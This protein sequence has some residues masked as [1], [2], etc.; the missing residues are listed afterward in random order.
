MLVRDAGTVRFRVLIPSPPPLLPALSRVSIPPA[1][2]TPLPLLAL[3]LLPFLQAAD[4]RAR[5]GTKR[6][7]D[8]FVD[9]CVLAIN[10]VAQAPTHADPTDALAKDGPVGSSGAGGNDS[11]EAQGRSPCMGPIAAP[12]SA[13][14]AGDGETPVAVAGTTPVPGGRPSALHVPA[15]SGKAPGASH[16]PD[17]SSPESPATTAAAAPSYLSAS[18]KLEFFEGARLAM[19][20]TALCLS[21]GGALAM[22]HMG[23]VRALIQADTMPRIVSGTS[24]GAIV[25]GMLAIRTDK[26][27]V[28]DVI[29]SDI[30]DRYGVT[31][32]DPIPTQVAT[33]AA[34]LLTSDRPYTM[35]SERFAATCKRYFG[36][37]TF[38][39]AFRRTGRVVSIVIT[40]RYGE[41]GATHPFLA[42]YLTCPTV[43]IWSAVAAS[44]A[45]PG[46]M[47][48]ANLVS[49]PPQAA[50]AAKASAS[51]SAASWPGRASGA[52]AGSPTASTPTTVSASNPASPRSGTPALTGDATS[53]E[54]SADSQHEDP[55]PPEGP[56]R[57]PHA[58][59]RGG[60]TRAARP[61]AT[62]TASSNRGGTRAP[63]E[64]V[65]GP[66]DGVPFHPRGVHALDG[67]MQSDIP[68]EALARL[69][70]V[71]RFV[72]SQ[73]NPHIA[74]FLREDHHSAA[75]P[76]A[77]GTVSGSPDDDGSALASAAAAV[78]RGGGGGF[79]ALLSQ[80]RLWLTLDVQYRAHRLARLRLLPRF[81]GADVSGIFTQRYRGHVTIS[82]RMSLL[83]QF[84]A[85]SHPSRQ[86]MER[87]ISEGELATW[88]R[89]PHIATT[90]RAEKALSRAVR[91]IRPQAAAER[92]AAERMAA[93]A[94]DAAALKEARGFGHQP[95]GGASVE[96]QRYSGRQRQLQQHRDCQGQEL[97][98][99]PGANGGVND[100]SHA[101]QGFTRGFASMEC[102]DFVA[103]HHGFDARRPAR[104]HADSAGADS[105]ELACCS[106]R[107]GATSS[108]G[109][110]GDEAWGK[111]SPEPGYWGHGGGDADVAPGDGVT[112]SVPWDD[113]D[114]TG[115]ARDQASPSR[116]GSP[117]VGS[118][119][120]GE[121]QPHHAEQGLAE[122][123]SIAPVP[124]V[125]MRRRTAATSDVL[126]WDEGSTSHRP[127][128]G[129]SHEMVPRLD[130]DDG[131]IEAGLEAHSRHAAAEGDRVSP[132]RRR[133]VG[134]RTAAASAPVASQASRTG[135]SAEPEWGGGGPEGVGNGRAVG[136][137]IALVCE[138]D[139][140]TG[141]SDVGRQTADDMMALP[142]GR[143][144]HDRGVSAPSTGKLDGRAADAARARALGLASSA[145]HRPVSESGSDTGD[146][147]AIA[148]GRARRSEGKQEGD[149]WTGEWAP[150]HNARSGSLPPVGDRAV[151]GPRP[152]HA[153][154]R[155]GHGARRVGSGRGSASA[156]VSVAST[157]ARSW[158]DSMAP[159]VA[160]AL[161]R[162]PG[163]R[164]E[165]KR[166]HDATAAATAELLRTRLGASGED[167]PQRR[168]RALTEM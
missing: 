36:A 17:P 57:R 151:M 6:L 111:D 78:S 107:G 146:A 125:A 156:S 74:P 150:R 47:P 115:R 11:G 62:T 63:A 37:Y 21:G 136:W 8:R 121:S 73:V 103:D 161:N 52:G 142:R 61:S 75:L 99:R 19:G 105:A 26:E 155:G 28:D 34:S 7:V 100:A 49:K 80:V 145:D 149:A 70:H 91:R 129:H 55:C 45:L 96:P 157:P 40:V 65:L 14:A 24:G 131:L 59:S 56:T 123:G 144:G 108:A 94:R 124:S 152:L 53:A 85:L 128:D 122:P 86:D 167:R 79:A 67:S 165:L 82:P 22:Y 112:E 66:L 153:R 33:F 64:S 68:G 127:A 3:S 101:H 29:A 160:R 71:N 120:T 97:R 130:R 102:D 166:S 88:P 159:Y 140:S 30:A 116:R 51:R 16:D 84:K 38:G 72:T 42:N 137:G 93:V 113:V 143:A 134:H 13:T 147:L 133:P 109:P 168:G 10:A 117:G 81:F 58:A 132:S 158:R 46:L 163:G 118:G 18:D 87:Y 23:V 5:A 69:F 39:E 114:G 141:R 139:G 20:R 119:A 135:Q 148:H 27:M 31:W 2:R 154:G 1:H 32:F 60:P 95:V 110:L 77:Q 41:G 48:A 76:P 89:L 12:T 104:A 90:V 9:E 4:H 164:A 83:D 44:C 35:R 43:F 98:C 126:G 138:V 15:P 50:A 54:L 25:A 92:A 162:S 106:E